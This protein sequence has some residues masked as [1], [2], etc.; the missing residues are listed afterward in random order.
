MAKRQIGRGKKV[1]KPIKPKLKQLKWLFYK[2]D[3][4]LI[5]SSAA[6]F[7]FSFGYKHKAV[8][9]KYTNKYH[10]KGMLLKRLGKQTAALGN[11][12][13]VACSKNSLIDD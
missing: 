3:C 11:E 7:L 2:N 10:Y 5:R 13:V 1:Q 4:V 6:K 12:F 9:K 8:A